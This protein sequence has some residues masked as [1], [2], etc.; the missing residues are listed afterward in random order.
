MLKKKSSIGM[1][2]DGLVVTFH[3]RGRRYAAVRTFSQYSTGHLLLARNRGTEGPDWVYYGGERS[4]YTK[5][6]ITAPE[7]L[8]SCKSQPDF[9]VALFRFIN[10]QMSRT[11]ALKEY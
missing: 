5:F 8:F 10:M 4:S 2:I 9:L 6:S 11:F 3:I 7:S 1:S